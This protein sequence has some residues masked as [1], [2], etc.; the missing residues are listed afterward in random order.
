MSRLLA[1]PTIAE[2]DYVQSRSLVG[3]DGT[4][5][6]E[7]NKAGGRVPLAPEVTAAIA[8]GKSGSLVATVNGRR[9]Q[10]AYHPLSS[11]DW[12]YVAAGEVGRMMDSKEKIVT[13]D[14]RKSIAAP[15]PAPSSRSI[16]GSP[17]PGAA[18]AAPLAEADAGQEPTGDGGASDAGLP[19]A[20]SG[21][22]GPM[23]KASAAA[24]GEPPVP[25]NPF[26]KWKVYERKKK[27]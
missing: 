11:V 5:M 6:A 22:P 16:A 7:D 1:R 10:Y 21:V 2:L 20:R 17:P 9:Y 18:P 3:R 24:S 12:Y 13:S 14:P 26:E 15:S 19:R 27:P 23:P 8:E 4:L 25:P